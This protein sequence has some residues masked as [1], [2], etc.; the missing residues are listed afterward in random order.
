MTQIL[1]KSNQNKA[2]VSK[3]VKDKKYFLHAVLMVIKFMEKTQM[4][5]DMFNIRLTERF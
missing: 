2:E 1:M 5:G 4:L 3:T